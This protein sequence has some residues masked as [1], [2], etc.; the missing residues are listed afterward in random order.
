MIEHADRSATASP[1]NT[2]GSELLDGSGN[3]LCGSAPIWLVMNLKAD[4]YGRDARRPY[5]IPMKGWW[6]VA[7]R[8]WSE[9]SR[10]PIDWHAIKWIKTAA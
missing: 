5:Q 1:C 9:S 6:Q 8:V 2:A 10:P 3:Y 7:Q 4:P